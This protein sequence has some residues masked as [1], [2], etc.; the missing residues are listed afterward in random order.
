M[1]PTN[2]TPAKKMKKLSIK[3]DTVKNL[4]AAELQNVVGGLRSTRPNSFA[5]SCTGSCKLGC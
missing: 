1:N 5:N 2:K 4:S 3:L